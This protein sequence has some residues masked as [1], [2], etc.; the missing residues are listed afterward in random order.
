VLPDRQ[1]W[2][3]AGSEVE[4]AGTT[5]R[6][7]KVEVPDDDNGAVYLEQIAGPSL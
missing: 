4:V 5:W 3:G 1:V 6:V 2:V 7:T